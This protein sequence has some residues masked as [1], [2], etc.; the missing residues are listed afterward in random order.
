MPWVEQITL[1]PSR[2][3][4]APLI[5]H[6]GIRKTRLVGFFFPSFFSCLHLVS[7]IRGVF[8]WIFIRHMYT[9]ATPSAKPMVCLLHVLLLDIA[10]FHFAGKTT[11]TL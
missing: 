7:L 2:N 9:K 10:I 1:C 3:I 4:L 11:I 8:E 6:S 5:W